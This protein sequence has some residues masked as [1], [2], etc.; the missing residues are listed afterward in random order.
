MNSLFGMDFEL[1]KEYEDA[2]VQDS[3]LVGTMRVNQDFSKAEI[4]RPGF[5]RLSLGFFIDD[6]KLEFILNAI[7][8]VCEHGWK[9]LP[10]YSFNLETGEWRHRH[11]QIFKNRKWLGNITYKNNEFCFAKKVSQLNADTPNTDQ[12]KLFCITF[13]PY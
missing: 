4:L 7:K 9:F 8:F 3:R 10:L 2:L 5:V 1:V 11:H 12:V 6:S 13:K